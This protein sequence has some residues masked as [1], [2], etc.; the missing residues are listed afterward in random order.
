M[1]P[2]QMSDPEVV[3]WRENRGLVL[4][5]RIKNCT[6]GNVYTITRI[7]LDTDLAILAESLVLQDFEVYIESCD[8]PA[9]I[10]NTRLNTTSWDF[11]PSKFPDT[12]DRV[13]AVIESFY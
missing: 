9:K 4:G 1:K 3:Q 13:V 12:R 11:L 5:A 7:Q 10:F 6:S 2:L 8:G